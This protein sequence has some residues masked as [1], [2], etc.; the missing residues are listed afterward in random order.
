MLLLPEEAELALH[1]VT[2]GGLHLTLRNPE[3]VD[4]QEE[5]GR[6]TINTLLTSERGKALLTLRLRL[7]AAR[8]RLTADAE[9]DPLPYLPRRKAGGAR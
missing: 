8:P 2:L 3:D 5:R 6:S 7:E 9:D 4:Y 1:A